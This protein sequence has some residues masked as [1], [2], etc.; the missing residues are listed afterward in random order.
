VTNSSL[1][2]FGDPHIFHAW[3]KLVRFDFFTK[4]A[5]IA[6]ISGLLGVCF[7]P[8]VRFLYGTEFVLTI[9]MLLTRKLTRNFAIT[10]SLQTPVNVENV[11]TVNSRNLSSL[12][13]VKLTLPQNAS[14]KDE[15]EN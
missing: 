10:A 13:A 4:V 14:R 5:V 3:L 9:L 15:K 12:C 1:G 8:K 6:I 7:A 11:P 2:G